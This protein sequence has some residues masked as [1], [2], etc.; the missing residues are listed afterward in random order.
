MLKLLRFSGLLALFA[1]VVVS[2]CHKITEYPQQP[3]T[4]KMGPARTVHLRLMWVDDIDGVARNC[5]SRQHSITYACAQWSISITDPDVS[6]CT[7]FAVRARDF[8][9]AP[10]LAILGHELEHCTGSIH[11]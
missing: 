1:A 5:P 7:I 4:V 11:Q 10:L 2:S 9:D 8:N 6:F 3:Q